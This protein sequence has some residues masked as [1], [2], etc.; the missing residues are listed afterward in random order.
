MS[1]LVLLES[2]LQL[3]FLNLPLDLIQRMPQYRE[4]AGHQF[5]TAH[6]A[7]EYPAG[8]A[9]NALI[10]PASGD[11]YRLTCLNLADTESFEPYRVNFTRDRHGFRNAQPWDDDVDIVVVGDSFVAA[12]SVREP[13]WDGIGDSVLAFGLP[14]SGTLEQFLLLQAFGL[15][16]SPETVVVA[17]FAGNDLTDNQIFADLQRQGLNFA[18]KTHRERNPLEYLVTVHIALFLRDR[19]IA[20]AGDCH[21]PQLAQTQPPTP[22]A[23]YDEML[24]TLAIDAD[25][26]ASSAMFQETK[27]A[28]AQLA[29]DLRQRRIRLI[30]MYIP[31]KAEIFWNRL[32]QTGKRAIVAALGESDGSIAIGEIDKNLSA[33][34]N[35][36]EGDGR[37]NTASNSWTW[38][39]CCRRLSMKGRRPIFSPIPT[40][41]SAGTKSPQQPCA[42]N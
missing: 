3:A 41:I 31:Q 9:V 35:L 38:F 13:F 37:G 11:L 42:N 30:L 22:V 6:G 25:E 36:L 7:R 8:E 21:Y 32:G 27:S 40:G 1:L 33:Q 12:E 15:P 19:L 5:A 16:R 23:F 39:H 20:A 18:E 24:R 34:R 17:F 2:G 4:R 14:G 10:T 28:L 26:L 29:A